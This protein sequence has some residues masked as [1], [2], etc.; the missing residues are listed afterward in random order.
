MSSDHNVIFKKS[1]V[2]LGFFMIHVSVRNY[3]TDLHTGKR[4]KIWSKIVPSG[5]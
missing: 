3:M 2:I 5:D 1:S 4:I